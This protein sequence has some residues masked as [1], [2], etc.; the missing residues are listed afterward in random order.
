L[1]SPETIA[2]LRLLLSRATDGEWHPGHL[3]RDD[4]KCDCAYI[5]SEGRLGGVL[6]VYI[7]NEKPISE[8]GNDA[9]PR[10]EAKANLALV[11]L[12]KNCLPDLLDEI[13][14]ARSK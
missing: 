6:E 1:I 12:M 3:T 14:K 4:L 5:L 13:E 9:P 8:G 7:D 2:E 10:E 11:A